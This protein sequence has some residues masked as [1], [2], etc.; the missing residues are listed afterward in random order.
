MRRGIVF[1]SVVLSVASLAV[2]AAARSVR[3]RDAQDTASTNSDLRQLGYVTHARPDGDVRARFW[4]DTYGG[5]VFLS[6]LY[7]DIDTTGGTGADRSIACSLN[8]SN[9]ELG[10]K[11]IGFG[12]RTVRG[13]DRLYVYFPK[14]MLGATKPIAWRV[15]SDDGDDD[16]SDAAPGWTGWYQS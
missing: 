16:S 1:V 7:I 3:Y 15:R 8:L 12:T 10:G 14:R 2:P 6:A 5:R 13:F 9:C 11:A 4:L